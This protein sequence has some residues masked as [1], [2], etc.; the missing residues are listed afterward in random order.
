MPYPMHSITPYR[1]TSADCG[2]ARRYRIMKGVSTKGDL[3]MKTLGALGL[4]GAALFVTFCQGQEAALRP[5]G[6]GKTPILPSSEIRAGMQG[7]A[8]TV[9]Q[10]TKPEPIPVEI[11][12][13]YKNA[14]GPKQAI[15]LGKLGGKAAR[16]NVAGGMSGSP[17][18][19]DGKLAGAISTRIS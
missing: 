12:G 2:S 14:A 10:G 5:P 9:V 16:T 7:V 19:I 11:I 13:L 3:C 8:W 1:R 4:L 6:I 15:I 18:Y 17:V